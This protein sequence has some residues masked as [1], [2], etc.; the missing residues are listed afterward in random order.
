MTQTF[1][2]ERTL[3]TFSQLQTQFNLQRSTNEQF[4]PEWLNIDTELTQKE[5]Q[6]LDAIQLI[7]SFENFNLF[8]YK[9]FKYV[10]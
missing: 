8:Y 1:P 7:T 6:T 9:A 2:I 5:Q 10:H 4:F 3:K